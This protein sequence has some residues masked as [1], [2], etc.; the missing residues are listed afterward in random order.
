MLS[1]V[2]EYLYW[3]SRYLERSKHVARLIDV[4]LFL[5]LDQNPEYKVQHWK[6]LFDSLRVPAGERLPDGAYNVA[7]KLLFDVAN[8][9]SLLSCINRARDNARQVREQISTEMWEQLNRLFLHIKHK[10]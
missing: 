9:S 7:Q 8:S 3:M 4:S 1:R 6:R 5:L 10:S 2:G